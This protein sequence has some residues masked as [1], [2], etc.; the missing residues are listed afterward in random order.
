MLLCEAGV[1]S[2][3]SNSVQDVLRLLYF[4]YVC[5]GFFY[6]GLII[7]LGLCLVLFV[8]R[9]KIHLAH[10]PFQLLLL[11]CLY[12]LV[13]FLSFTM[14]AYYLSC[15]KLHYKINFTFECPLLLSLGSCFEWVFVLQSN[16]IIMQKDS[17]CTLDKQIFYCFENL[18]QSHV[19]STYSGSLLEY[20]FCTKQLSKIAMK[21]FDSITSLAICFSKF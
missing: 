16:S 14:I 17:S 4:F 6:L 9:L 10:H 5:H 3:Q 20:D 18:C 7:V 19:R 15:S 2:W 11:N 21:Q 13:S 12:I 8:V 1:Q